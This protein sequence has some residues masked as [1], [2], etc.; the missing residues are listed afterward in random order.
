VETG[1]PGRSN[2]FLSPILTTRIESILLKGT[3][4]HSRNL[5]LL[6]V[7]YNF[8]ISREPSPD[9]GKINRNGFPVDPD[10][11]SH[12]YEWAGE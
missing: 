1:M 9:A 8:S 12:S 4:L 11:D 10:V 6:A 5:H 2:H 3:P 7:I